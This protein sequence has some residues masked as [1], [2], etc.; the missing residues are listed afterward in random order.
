MDLINDFTILY[1]LTA[2]NT[3]QITVQICSDI[4][5]VENLFAVFVQ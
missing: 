4:Y 2:A 5:T 3:I 1:Y